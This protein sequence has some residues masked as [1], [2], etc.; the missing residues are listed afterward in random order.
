MKT[1]AGTEY[2]LVN[3]YNQPVDYKMHLTTGFL[4]NGIKNGGLLEPDTELLGDFAINT[5][6]QDYFFIE[7]NNG[8]EKGGID[9][10][11]L[12][13]EKAYKFYVFGSRYDTNDRTGLLTFTGTNSYQGT[14]QMGGANIAEGDITGNTKN[15][16]N[17]TIFVS[18]AIY[19]DVDGTIHFELARYAGK[20][21]HSMQ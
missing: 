5:A 15:Q 13:P 11:N 6:T 14:H 4:S 16:N 8:A 7:E 18:E 12:K 17:N 3:S 21:A 2:S 19:P 20:F 10:K 9:F 1:A